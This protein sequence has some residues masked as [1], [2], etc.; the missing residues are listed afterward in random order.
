MRSITNMSGIDN[1]TFSHCQ[2]GEMT[3]QTV[4]NH[5]EEEAPSLH[6]IAPCLSHGGWGGASMGRWTGEDSIFSPKSWAW[7]HWTDHRTRLCWRIILSCGWRWTGAC[8]WFRVGNSIIGCSIE[9]IVFCDWKID[10]IVKKIKSLLSIF[11]KDRRD[12][13]A[14]GRR[15]V[16]SEKYCTIFNNP[17]FLKN[18]ENSYQAY[19]KYFWFKLKE[20]NILC[21]CN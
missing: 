20:K 2:S 5:S 9:L 6:C 19:H 18:D 11:T 8:T 15:W 4:I 1:R 10:L 17:R 12:R 7:T 16:R 3:F 13:F 21:K 14:H